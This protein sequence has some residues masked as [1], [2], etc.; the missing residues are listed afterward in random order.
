MEELRPGVSEARLLPRPQGQRGGGG[1]RPHCRGRRGRQDGGERGGGVGSGRREQEARQVETRHNRQK[2]YHVKIEN[3]AS[4][5]LYAGRWTK[6]T[7]T[8]SA[9]ERA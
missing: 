2:N 7:R 6:K 3:I 5:Q 9:S 1:G 4:L 8:T